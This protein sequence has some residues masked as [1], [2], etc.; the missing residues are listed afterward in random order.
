MINHNQLAADILFHHVAHILP[1]KF[2]TEMFIRFGYPLP[3][4]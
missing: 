1:T 2:S 4:I 3:V